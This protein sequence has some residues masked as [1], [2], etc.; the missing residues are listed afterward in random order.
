M[1]LKQSFLN[2]EKKMIELKPFKIKEKNHFR[3]EVL[4][5]KNT[6]E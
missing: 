4:T 1:I 2:S 3:N 6:R 5:R